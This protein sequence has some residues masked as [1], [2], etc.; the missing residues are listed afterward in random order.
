MKKSLAFL[1]ALLMGF[2]ASSCGI[3]YA[4]YHTSQT[5]DPD[6]YES[7]HNGSDGQDTSFLLDLSAEEDDRVLSV[8][9]FSRTANLYPLRNEIGHVLH[10]GVVG[11]FGCPVRI[12]DSSDLSDAK[13]VFTYDKDHMDNIPPTNLIVLKAD[14]DT[15]LYETVPSKLDENA[16]TVTVTVTEPGVYM[17]ADSYAWGSA[18]GEYDAGQAHDTVWRCDEFSFEM[19]IPQEIH[20]IEVGDY[21][22]EDEDG[23]CKTLLECEY[24]E[25]IQ[26]G[27]EYLERPFYDSCKDFMNDMAGQIDQQGY[28]K[29]TGTIKEASGRT[30][31]YWY[32]DFS[33]PGATVGS[34]SINCIVP[35]SD[36][37]YINIWYGFTDASYLDTVMDSLHS[38]RFTGEPEVPETGSGGSSYTE[39]SCTAM[40]LSLTPPVGVTYAP[41]KGDWRDADGNGYAKSRLPLL[42]FSGTSQNVRSV[43][44]D[45]EDCRRNACKVATDDM[46]LLQLQGAKLIDS[47]QISLG[48]SLSGYLFSMENDGNTE[49][50]GY[51]DIP[52]SHQYV[53]VSVI[54][55]PGTDPKEQEAYWKMLESFTTAAPG[56]EAENLKLQYPE[57]FFTSPAGYGK[58]SR[59]RDN[60]GGIFYRRILMDTDHRASTYGSDGWS[61]CSGAFFYV[62]NSGKSAQ[63]AMQKQLDQYLNSDY[64][65][66][67]HITD[68]AEVTLS[69]GQ[70]GYIF[71]LREDLQEGDD[72]RNCYM[73]GF[74]DVSDAEGNPTG[75]YVEIDFWLREP[76]Q[77]KVYKDFWNCLK[78][79]DIVW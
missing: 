11:R 25:N 35:L 46:N 31:Y 57:H 12:A 76:T 67:I 17:L 62:I 18:W 75:Q 24:N 74:Y 38:L 21:L 48:G 9:L 29:D 58:W 37:Q 70:K 34:H 78:T 61:D 65:K 68:Q 45:L 49:L 27:I 4:L 15:Q 22:K 71:A 55:L 54:L 39:I 59:E 42:E 47:K 2:S 43:S 19:T 63:E 77:D 23:M 36:T 14:E 60:D 10:K 73:Y 28:L 26:I 72:Y 6:R 69:G 3:L 7:D 8:E 16:G 32:A 5:V 30:C 52:D 20:L 13:L 79:A 53:R 51:Y 56:L 50:Y 33:D 66:N 44:A 1:A 40:D 64:Y 41:A